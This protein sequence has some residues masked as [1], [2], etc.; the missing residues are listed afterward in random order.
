M[1]RKTDSDNPADW[2]LVAEADLAMVRHCLGDDI[3]FAACQAKLAEAI[4]KLLKAEL[5]RGGWKLLKTHDLQLLCD[6]LSLRDPV[7]EFEVRPLCQSHS[8]S[9]LITRY[10][11]FDLDDPDWPVLRTQFEAVTALAAE[12][13]R[14][15]VSP[16]P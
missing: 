8:E 9:Y 4:E 6:E 16:P 5:I 10:P 15:L 1:P 11:G 7:L 13:H 14:R 2:L 12:I 3:A